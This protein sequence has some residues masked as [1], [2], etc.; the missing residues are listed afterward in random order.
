MNNMSFNNLISGNNFQVPILNG[1]KVRYVNF[2]NAASTPPFTKVINKVNEFTDI[3]SSVHRGN[4]F[5]SIL[6]TKVYEETRK[7]IGDF[8]G[9]EL[10]TNAV[11]YGKNATEAI[12]KLASTYNFD[13][14]D[15]VLCTRME[16]H[17]NDLPWRSKATVKYVEVKENGELDICQLED[18]LKM[19]NGKIKLVTVT[20]ASNVTGYIN[21][22]HEIA[23]LAHKAGAKIMVDGSQLVP[24]REID[25]KDDV[26]IEH[27]DFLVFTA[28]KIYS[29]FG[30][31]VL[32]GPRD[33]FNNAEPEMSGG[34]TV[35]IVT[36]DEVYWEETP[37]KNEAGTPNIIGAVALA[38]SIRFL[39]I[40]GI[41]NI[42]KNENIL[43]EYLLKKLTVIKG[44][45][46]YGCL[47]ADINRRLG[48]IAFNIEGVS[49]DL[50]AAILSYEYGIGVRNGCFC[51]H[52]YVLRLLNVDKHEIS[53]YK[54]QVLKGDKTK[55][56][57][58][59]RISFGIYNTI[60]DID[61]LLVAIDN[62][63]KGKYFSDYLLNDKEGMYTPKNWTYDYK[64]SFDL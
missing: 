51:A 13:S 26:D 45:R 28:H 7:V 11:I 1:E 53:D 29:P 5:K 64:S 47:D 37:E 23:R 42:E 58:L 62:I 17:S 18:L 52:P 31:G 39:R 56:P 9:V 8:L 30:I 59:V 32:I 34:G 10:L 14:G 12:N 49:H 24:H 27:I 48:V 3:Y 33:F 60:E 21:P 22:I 46:I 55:L 61:R 44:I 41:S 19:Y 57:G 2:D 6:S 20:G 35:K 25:I 63:S 4:G 50:V 40:L 54:E 43:V 16:H 15:I 36:D 38:S